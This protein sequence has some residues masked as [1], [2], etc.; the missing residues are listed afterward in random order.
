VPSS[1]T[2]KLIVIDE[3]QIDE[4][5]SGPTC[6]TYSCPDQK[7]LRNNPNNIKCSELGF[8]SCATEICC[9]SPPP[10]TLAQLEAASRGARPGVE[11]LPPGSTPPSVSIDSGKKIEIENPIILGDR[12]VNG[13][14]TTDINE[15]IYPFSAEEGKTY[16]I[17]V[18]PGTL[19]DTVAQLID[20]DMATM[21]IE[22]DDDERVGAS[23]YGS[24]IEWDCNNTGTYYALVKA[25]DVDIGTF[26]I[27]VTESNTPQPGQEPQPV[28]A[29][30]SD[31][32]QCIDAHDARHGSTECAMWANPNGSYN[33]CD[34]S[35]SM[36]FMT[37]TADKAG[38]CCLSCCR[39]GK[40][41]RCSTSCNT[42]GVGG[43]GGEDT[44]C[45]NVGAG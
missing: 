42:L 10:P 25:W 20:T 43:V 11:Y 30:S 17:E 15:L 40:P 31:G 35:D 26:N 22:N 13:E 21:I 45:N 2:F 44:S 41:G 3:D 9:T 19:E 7:V 27:S 37:G 1:G 8:D 32:E 16:Q 14:V 39:V 23:S 38:E 6:A 36:A 24:F 33:W 28:T 5:Q 34:N 29:I 18:T 12:G 4:D